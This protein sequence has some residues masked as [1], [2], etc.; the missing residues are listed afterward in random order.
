MIC[1]GQWVYHIAS[2]TNRLINISNKGKRQAVAYDADS[3]YEYFL[4]NDCQNTC[5]FGVSFIYYYNARFVV[6]VLQMLRDSM[7]P[8]S[9]KNTCSST[10]TNEMKNGFIVE[11]MMGLVSFFLHLAYLKSSLTS[12]NQHQLRGT[13]LIEF[14]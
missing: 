12:R 8:V 14:F 13:V 11:A 9:K 10:L 7:A 2:S 1:I 6:Q 4:F 3:R 5:V